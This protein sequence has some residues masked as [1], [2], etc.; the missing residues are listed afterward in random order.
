MSSSVS[1][2]SLAPPSSWSWAFVVCVVCSC[3]VGL[4]MSWRMGVVGRVGCL[5]LLF[6]KSLSI[7]SHF[8]PSGAV[9]SQVVS[10]VTSLFSLL[11]LFGCRYVLMSACLS[12]M[13]FLV[14]VTFFCPDHTHKAH[15]LTK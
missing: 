5:S 6:T 8:E 15:N 11:I 10:L 4:A 2:S 3:V 9:V 13:V 1:L 7:E 12:W 14:S